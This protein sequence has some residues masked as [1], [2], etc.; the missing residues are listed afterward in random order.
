MAARAMTRSALQVVA[1]AR[2][3]THSPAEE[4][5]ERAEAKSYRNTAS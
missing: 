3:R 5:R 1:V 4:R 2:T